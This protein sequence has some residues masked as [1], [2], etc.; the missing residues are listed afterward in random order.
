M[1]IKIN[2]RVGAMASASQDTVDL[3]GFGVYAGEEVPPEDVRFMGEPIT[4]P[5][6]KIVLDNGQ[7]VWGCEC[8][9]AD[10]AK[11]KSLIGQRPVNF[12]DIEAAR[13]ESNA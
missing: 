6:T 13:R 8:W 1:T 10:E 9:W 3:F 4:K 7:V 2:D 12:I 11:I 5:N